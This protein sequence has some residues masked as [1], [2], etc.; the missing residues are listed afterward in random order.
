MLATSEL[1]VRYA[2]ARDSEA[3]AK[4]E[5]EGYTGHGTDIYNI[6]YPITW[7]QVHPEG[8]LVTE[9][10]GNIVAYLYAQR[11]TIGKDRFKDL[12]LYTSDEKDTDHG[13]T[14]TTHVPNGN[15]LH[16]VSVLSAQ[17]GS[18][19]AMNLFLLNEARKKRTIRS[20]FACSRLPGFRAYT[21]TIVDPKRGATPDEYYL[22]AVWYCRETARL[23]GGTVLPPF[24]LAQ[25]KW[26]PL[27]VADPVAASY[28]KSGFALS[29]L[30][31]EW[32]KDPASAG[33]L[34]PEGTYGFG[35]MMVLDVS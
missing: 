26:K 12:E 24:P 25:I 9:K 32:L 20:I 30:K 33:F 4:L 3:I 17:K 29:N 18:A 11:R 35:A 27:T 10:G 6:S 2:H 21:Q 14:R 19:R 7:L 22:M 8:L 15:A 16:I 23:T 34:S 13:Y 1:H 31:Q 28:F 5:R